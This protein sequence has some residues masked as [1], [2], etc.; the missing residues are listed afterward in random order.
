MRETTSRQHAAGIPLSRSP[1]G[2][3]ASSDSK[4]KRTASPT[5]G[6]TPEASFKKAK[7]SSLGTPQSNSARPSA[8]PSPH[9]PPS[10]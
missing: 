6:T 5:G 3:P 7:M 9:P 2:T 4:G 1:K 10:F 8:M